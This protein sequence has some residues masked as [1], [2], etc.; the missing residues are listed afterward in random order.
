[1]TTSPLACKEETGFGLLRNATMRNAKMRSMGNVAFK[2]LLL[3]LSEIRRS[4]QMSDADSL[5]IRLKQKTEVHD[6]SENNNLEINRKAHVLRK[7]H[8]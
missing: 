5:P 2:T 6:K 4:P 8:I 1:M 7:I 3:H